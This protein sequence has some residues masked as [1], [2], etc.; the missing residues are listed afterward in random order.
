MTETASTSSVRAGFRTP[1]GSL[2]KTAITDGFGSTLIE[3]VH[4]PS[5][6]VDLAD[7]DRSPRFRLDTA[8]GGVGPS[9]TA[10]FLISGLGPAGPGQGAATFLWTNEAVGGRGDRFAIV[11]AIQEKSEFDAA[12]ADLFWRAAEVD[13][14]LAADLV[15]LDKAGGRLRRAATHRSSRVADTKLRAES[16][17]ILVCACANDAFTR[18]TCASISSTYYAFGDVATLWDLPA[19]GEQ[20]AADNLNGHASRL[21]RFTSIY[22]AEDAFLAD[23]EFLLLLPA[24]AVV[25]RQLHVLIEEALHH[26]DRGKLVQMRT[27]GETRRL[28]ALPIVD[29]SVMRPRDFPLTSFYPV[30]VRTCD[31]REI[32]TGRRCYGSALSLLFDLLRE[33]DVLEMPVGPD[34]GVVQTAPPPISFDSHQVARLVRDCLEAT[35]TESA[36]KQS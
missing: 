4:A 33:L 8:A 19:E 36:R 30:L 22:A 14:D 12:V 9:L 10:S 15:R 35:V 21:E 32:L 13:L 26:L 29:T 7:S 17:A 28:D 2:L 11:P 6:M 3:I 27:E 18:A 25:S 23:H 31:V 1:S 24:G 5:E 16:V 20:G 34:D